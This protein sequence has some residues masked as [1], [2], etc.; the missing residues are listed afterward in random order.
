MSIRIICPSCRKQ[1]NLAETMQGKTVVCRE[2]Q[3]RID[4]PTLA[5][6][7]RDEQASRQAEERTAISTRPASAAGRAS[8]EEDVRASTPAGQTPIPP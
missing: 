5:R 8:R 2:C 7:G 1:Y 4:V 3:S 6:K